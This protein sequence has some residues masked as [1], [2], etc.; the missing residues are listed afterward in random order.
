MALALYAGFLFELKGASSAAITVLIP[1]QPSQGM[2]LSKA[3]DR[4]RGRHRD[5]ERLPVLVERHAL[6][7][8]TP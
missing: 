4:L 8:P 5:D 3:L 1:A 6:M 2:A 7:R